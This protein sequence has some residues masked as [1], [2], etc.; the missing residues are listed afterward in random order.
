MGPVRVHLIIQ[1]QVNV[2]VEVH[3][4][5]QKKRSGQEGSKRRSKDECHLGLTKLRSEGGPAMKSNV[6]SGSTS[7]DKY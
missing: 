4:S 7:K 6:L 3:I 2:I 5:E 1:R